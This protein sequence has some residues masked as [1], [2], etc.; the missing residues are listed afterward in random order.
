[1][2]GLHVEMCDTLNVLSAEI[3]INDNCTKRAS[4]VGFRPSTGFF[5]R[6]SDSTRVMLGN[7][8]NDTDVLVIYHSNF[9]GD[10]KRILLQVAAHIPK[11]K[12]DVI[13]VAK[14]IIQEKSWNTWSGKR[15]PW[16][17][18]HLCLSP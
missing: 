12:V 16:N 17:G 18:P 4:S 13:Q 1:M 3:Y 5:R 15:E 8:G 10:S 14:R 2:D 11:E 7:D 6:V 9:K